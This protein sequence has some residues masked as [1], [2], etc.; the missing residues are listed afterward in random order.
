MTLRVFLC[1]S[2]DDTIL[3][4]AL[5]FLFRITASLAPDDVNF[6]LHRSKSQP[7]ERALRIVQYGV[8]GIGYHILEHI[9]LFLTLVRKGDESRM[10]NFKA[11][12][13]RMGLWDSAD[14]IDA[15]AQVRGLEPSFSSHRH[16]SVE[17]MTLAADPVE[18]C[19]REVLTWTIA[20]SGSGFLTQPSGYTSY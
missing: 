11:W 16:A 2:K 17:S 8:G 4:L 18:I 14:D 9:G 7:G 15:A 20:C 13:S 3:I 5:R 10:P 19:M 6:A 1:G 12:L